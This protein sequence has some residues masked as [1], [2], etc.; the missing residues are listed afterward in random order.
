MGKGGDKEVEDLRRA[1]L[2]GGPVR[3]LIERL[4]RLKR[5]DEAGALARVALSHEECPDKDA[6]ES[7]LTQAGCPPPGWTDAVIAFSRNPII[8]NWDSLMSF[9]PIGVLY[10]RIRNTLRLLRRIGTDPNALFRCATRDGI[11][12]DAFELVQSGEV[13][14]E[15]VVERA[16]AAPAGT[17]AMWLGIAAE[18]A[19]ARGDD[20]GTVRF[21]KMAFSMASQ[22]I[23]PE[24]SVIAIRANATEQQ[25]EMLDNAGIPQ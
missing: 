12:P 24:M 7:L 15:T 21:L 18:A 16:N 3:P 9:T 10:Q 14:P 20:L 13:D 11:V 6:I 19:F 23:G 5:V 25:N 4:L 1:W 8:E 17:R 22:G 2:D